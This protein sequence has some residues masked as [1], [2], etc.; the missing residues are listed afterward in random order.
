M[1]IALKLNNTGLKSKGLL[2]IVDSADGGVCLVEAMNNIKEVDATAAVN[3][4]GKTIPEGY[5]AI[6]PQR[7]E[8]QLT[9]PELPW[10]DLDFNKVHVEVNIYGEI[11]IN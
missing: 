7:E 11:D 8:V 1:S 9:S 4:N 6:D 2:C 5:V 3:I 10:K